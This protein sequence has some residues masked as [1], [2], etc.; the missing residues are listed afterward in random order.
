MEAVSFCNIF[1]EF[2][3]IKTM[4]KGGGDETKYKGGKTPKGGWRNLKGGLWSGGHYVDRLI[5]ISVSR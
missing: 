2:E 5:D 1:A 3:H 4:Q